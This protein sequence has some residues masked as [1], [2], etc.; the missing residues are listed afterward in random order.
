LVVYYSSKFQSD[1]FYL[2]KL[3]YFWFLYINCFRVIL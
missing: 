1:M 2:L 3:C